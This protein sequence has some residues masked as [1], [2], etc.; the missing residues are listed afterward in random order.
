LSEETPLQTLQLQVR[1][2]SPPLLA[3]EHVSM[4]LT[5]GMQAQGSAAS[6]E[7]SAMHE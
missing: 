2:T 3:Q 5:G 6:H 1:V 7:G 4:A